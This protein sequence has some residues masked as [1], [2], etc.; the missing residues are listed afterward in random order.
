LTRTH[1]LAVKDPAAALTVINRE[2]SLSL[3]PPVTSLFLARLDL[4][5]GELAYCNAGH[6]PPIR[7][8]AGGSHQFL[9]T[10]GP[11]LGA[12][13]DFKF[14]SGRVTLRPGDTLVGYSDG[15]LECRNERD[16]EFG[17]ERVL[18]E[19]RNSASAPPSVTLFSIIGAAQDFAGSQARED[20][21]TLLVV[22]R[23][24]HTHTAQPNRNAK[25]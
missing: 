17:V 11:L 5:S 12:V 14:I 1:G 13:P 22:R 15:L 21:C 19:A 8:E 24:S 25:R 16:E 2:V 7:L 18:H 23:K 9:N 3:A 20:D 4:K 6:P 10:G